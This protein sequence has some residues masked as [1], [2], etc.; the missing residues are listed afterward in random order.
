[1]IR[2]AISWF[3]TWHSEPIQ[4][5]HIPP[6]AIIQQVL[7]LQTNGL[8]QHASSGAGTDH[9]TLLTELQSDRVYIFLG[10]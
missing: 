9:L 2:A 5:A 10:S 6:I 1:M 8:S 3:P 4:N 7:I